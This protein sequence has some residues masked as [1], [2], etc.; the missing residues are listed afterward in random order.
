MMSPELECAANRTE[1][2]GGAVHASSQSRLCLS[3]QP[4]IHIRA[5][6]QVR[7]FAGWPKAHH[8]FLL[9]T[10][11]KADWELPLQVLRTAVCQDFEEDTGAAPNMVHV[12]DGRVVVGCSGGSFLELLQVGP[13]SSTC[14]RACYC[15]WACLRAGHHLDRSCTCD[16]AG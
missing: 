11:G 12:R 1:P 6:A 9:R 14:V 2:A 16:V 3:Q 7:A 13:G 15:V 8:T 4:C 10:P 5:L